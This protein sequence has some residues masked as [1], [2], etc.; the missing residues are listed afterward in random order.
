[1]FVVTVY[2]EDY[3]HSDCTLNLLQ[4]PQFFVTTIMV[5]RMFYKGVMSSSFWPKKGNTETEYECVPN[6]SIGKVAA[7]WVHIYS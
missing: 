4:K 6:G 7:L 2:S 1:M 3:I 5:S